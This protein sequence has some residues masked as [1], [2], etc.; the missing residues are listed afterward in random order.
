[1]RRLPQRADHIRQRV[2]L[3]VLHRVV[4]HAALAAHGVD[5]HDVC[6]VQAGRRLGF[7]LEALELPRVQDGGE[8]QHLERHAPAERKLLLIGQ[9]GDRSDDAI[10]DLARSAWAMRPDHV[11]IKEMAAYRRGRGP[12]DIPLVILDELRRL[13]L[14]ERQA[15][16]SPS[17]LAGVERALAWSRPGDLLVLTVHAERGRV[18]DLLTRR[19]AAVARGGVEDARG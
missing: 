18:E 1:M 15:E 3:D 9:A 19:V 7:V 12:Y 11:I 14:P 4:V 10:R 17:E 16:F 2:P 8:R 13:G 6:V 5:R